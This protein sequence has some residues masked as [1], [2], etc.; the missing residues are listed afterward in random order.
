MFKDLLNA[1]YSKIQWR[2]IEN[3]NLNAMKMKKYRIFAQDIVSQLL[4]S[5][6]LC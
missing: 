5:E 6:N 2:N 1:G 3:F 4:E